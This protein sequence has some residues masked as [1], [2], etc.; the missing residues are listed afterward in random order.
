MTSIPRM[1]IYESKFRPRGGGLKR[2][3]LILTE[4]IETRISYNLTN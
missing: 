3:K 4:S 2:G 1:K